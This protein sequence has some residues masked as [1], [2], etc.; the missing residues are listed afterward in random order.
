MARGS[1]TFPSLR[2]PQCVGLRT[3]LTMTARSEHQLVIFTL[4]GEQY[5]LPV[6]VVAEIVR[7]TAPTATAA[8]T[9]LVRGLINLRGRVLPVADLSRRLGQSLAV[10][11]A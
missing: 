6:D 9:E 7:Y 4:H 10:T 8:A 3:E 1:L 2:D 11:S 5:G